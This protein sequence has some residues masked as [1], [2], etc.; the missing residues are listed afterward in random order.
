MYLDCK[1]CSLGKHNQCLAG[2]GPVPSQLMI[3]GQ[4]PGLTEIR[5]GLPFQGKSGELLNQVLRQV[6]L[7][8]KE[9]YIT[10]IV[11]GYIAPGKN[12]SKTTVRICSS[13]HL[14]KEV[15]VVKP[16]VI[17]CL[18]A[19]AASFFTS[20]RVG[21][22]SYF[23]HDTYKCFIVITVHPARLFRSN[24]PRLKK[25]LVESFV[26]AKKLLTANVET[27]TSE[28]NISVVLTPEE[29][30]Q[31]FNTV[32]LGK[33]I[34]LDLE[35]TGFDFKSDSILVIGLSDGRQTVGI[36]FALFLDN[37]QYKNRLVALLASRE[38]ITQN[39]KFDAKFLLSNGIDITDNIVFDTMLASNLLNPNQ[40]H[41]LEALSSKYLHTYLTKGTIDFDNVE[42]YS[43]AELARY[44]GN[45]AWMT[46][47]VSEFLEQEIKE[48]RLTFLLENVSVPTLRYL[49]CAEFRGLQLNIEKLKAMVSTLDYKLKSI[50]A[51]ILQHPTIIAALKKLD[52]T[53]LNIKSPKQL[54]QILYDV[55]QLEVEDLPKNTSEATLT[56]IAEKYKDRQDLSFIP[57]LIEYRSLYKVKHT[58]L[59]GWLEISDE[60]GKIYPNFTQTVTAT[61]RLSCRKPNL[62]NI[63]K[64]GDL[65][66]QL[67]SCF[68][69][70]PGFVIIEADFKQLEFRLLGHYSQDPA[71]IEL[72]KAGKDIHRMVASNCFGK[73]EEEITKQERS[74]AKT[75]VFG[76][77]Y[78]R[79][80]WSI[81]R[82]FNITEQRAEQIVQ[83]FKSMFPKAAIWILKAQE[84]LK[85]TGYVK[86]SFGRIIPV[87]QIYSRDKSKVSHALR[88]AVNYPIQSLG[89]DIT[90][91]SGGLLHSYLKQRKMPA[92]LL[93]NIHD[94]L[95]CE[96]NESVVEQVKQLMKQ[97]MENEVPAKIK[98]RV[99]LKVD[100]EVK[101]TL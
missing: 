84:F 60:A 32:V 53:E 54:G 55:L 65:A 86:N 7:E 101:N 4:N 73:P 83:S 24:D 43:K 37:E 98:L 23:Y 15:E 95:I 91:M 29:L 99:P 69:P 51:S 40:P 56:A 94:A 97:V 8:R 75:V 66:K 3:V 63:P 16:K 46:F 45:D 33:R 19:K 10:N 52:L 76:V 39:G 81:A 41:S 47:K 89:A 77:I 57:L 100:I 90:N 88:C 36:D 42:Q 13:K 61:G 93:V 14:A 50:E 64:S 38:I 59:E 49:A 35:T 26:T 72:I 85:Q 31:F 28:P 6:G 70:A 27:S 18:G 82:Q 30:S 67:R 5:T 92:W 68:K 12:V 2:T 34:A 17:I 79:G 11:K 71:L 1:E 44:V 25:V 48:K 96:A 9:I 78:G 87:P 74:I 62:Q 22:G 21:I 80:T 58:Y 20:K